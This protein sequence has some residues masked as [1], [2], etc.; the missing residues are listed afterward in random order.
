MLDVDA[1]E[2]QVPGQ[3]SL[4]VAGDAVAVQYRPPG[5]GVDASGLDGCAAAPEAL[6][7]AD[8]WLG[9]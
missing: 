5:R 6:N 9:A 7:V 8:G 4:V 2:G 1:V 3:Q